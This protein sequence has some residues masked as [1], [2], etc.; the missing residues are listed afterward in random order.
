MLEKTQTNEVA[1]LYIRVSTM[2][3]SQKDSPEHQLA[4]TQEKAIQ[5]EFGLDENFVYEDRSSGTNISQREEI[6]RLVED[7]KKGLFN[8]VIFASLSRFSRDTLD[9]LTLKRQLVDSIGIRLISLDEGYDSLIDKDELKFQ[10]IS[11]VNQKL[12]EQI[13]ISSRRGIRES[14]KKGNYIGSKAPFGYKKTVTRDGK[15]TLIPDEE[16][17]KVVETIFTLYVKNNLGEKSIVNHLNDMKVPSPKGGTW[18]ISTIQ[19]I[20]QNEAYVGRNVFGKYTVKKE[21]PDYKDLNLRKNVLKQTPKENWM[22]AN[23]PNTH[24]PIINE[25]IF[26]EAQELRQKRGRGKRGGIRNKVNIFAGMIKCYHCNSSMVSMKSGKV[27]KAGKQYRYLICSSRRR[28]GVKGC[29]NGY[30][31]PYEQFRDEMITHLSE[32]L[33]KFVSSDNL[34]EKYNEVIQIKEYSAVK[35]VE[36]IRKQ[37]EI[38]RKALFQLRKEKVAGD[39][40]DVQYRFEKEQ[41]DIEIKNLE[42]KLANIEVKEKK[43][44]SII[45]LYEHINS[46]LEELMEINFENFD[47]THLTLQNLIEVITVSQSGDIQVDTKFGIEL[48]SNGLLKTTD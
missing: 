31:L 10:I 9:A 35:E 2:K 32:T 24:E 16:K 15:K 33:R 25:V 45:N 19:R 44:K 5:E 37:I 4:V 20:L 38:N 28:Q 29:V 21:Y 22:R 48:T 40:D 47:E 17:K 13:S 18:G 46:S 26:S 30:W 42:E 34:I 43:S 3:A 8:V 1:A 11:A 23:Q 12:S 6:K 7:A 27:S 39:I 14:A 41:C 36:K